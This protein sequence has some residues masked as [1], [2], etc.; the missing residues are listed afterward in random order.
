MDVDLGI[1]DEAFIL[2]S[3]FYTFKLLQYI[4]VCLRARVRV[5]IRIAGNLF[6]I[7]K[8]SVL[9]QFYFVTMASL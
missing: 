7:F 5:F 8:F 3:C 4:C 1:V 2:V 6:Y 9:S